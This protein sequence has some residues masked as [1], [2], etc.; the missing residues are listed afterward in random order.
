MLRNRV[1]GRVAAFVSAWLNRNGTDR[2][3]GTYRG[4]EHVK[5]AQKWAARER[6]S[7]EMLHSEA[8]A[9]ILASEGA[10]QARDYTGLTR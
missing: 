6:W 9:A 1:T 3:N 7:C 5:A 8:P 10:G 2:T 4:T